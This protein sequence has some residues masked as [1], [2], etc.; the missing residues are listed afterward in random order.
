MLQEKDR[1]KLDGIVKQMIAN[2][3]S[4]Q[5][6]QFV[7]NDFKSRYDLEA[8]Q[9]GG[10]ISDVKRANEERVQKTLSAVD[11]KQ[12]ILSKGLQVAGQAAGLATDV[13]GAGIKAGV[14]AVT[15]DIVEEGAKKLGLEI[16]QSSLGRKALQALGQGM[17]KY[18]EF[19]QKYPEASRNIEAVVNIAA[20][21]P[22][23]IGAKSVAGA[24]LKGGTNVLTKTAGALEK[25]AVATI[26]K[27][28]GSFVRDLVR[29][30]ATKSV[31]ESQVA[32]TTE[33]GTG[34]FK[35]SIIE[36]TTQE[37][38]AE[39]AVLA[40]VSG[41]SAEKTFQQNYNVIRTANTEEAIRLSDTI[42][43]N[44]FVIPKKE[45][46]SRLLEASKTLKESP[47]ITGD[48]ERTAQKLLSKAN[49]LVDD[50]SGTGS[51]ILKAR[52]QYD[53]WVQSQK[54]N[55]F[56]AKS[57]NAFTLANR[58]V[59]KVFNTLLDEKAPNLKVKD[60][61][62]EQS[63]L[64]TALENVTPKA[65][66]EANTAIGRL[67]QNAA[68]V[69]GTKNKIVQGVA[70]AVGIGGLGAAATFAPAAAVAGIGGYVVYRGG[71]LFVSPTARKAV[72][73]LLSELGRVLPTI[74]DQAIRSQLLLEVATTKEILKNIPD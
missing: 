69:L 57:E 12:N 50:N 20:L 40:K 2:K 62:R 32:R 6:I 18:D 5:D 55:A 7:V 51:G 68:K 63:A 29:P 3:E 4:D 26:E 54:P 31:K 24:E 14:K 70:A 43:K 9:K 60:S 35:R 48:A 49:Q 11:S 15:P 28:K 67:L 38:A 13:V 8:P 27:E 52:K 66:E 37:L 25:S 58:E 56:D 22:V 1:R 64:F 46:K 71:R 73:S 17:D 59:R 74:K 61:L 47:T 42:A 36:P 53:A 21:A 72:A 41:V 65:A 45:V 19:K 23:G 30:V 34:L 16:L 44:D 10:L 39:K 33:T